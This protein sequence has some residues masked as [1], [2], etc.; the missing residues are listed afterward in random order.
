MHQTRLRTAFLLIRILPV[1]FWMFGWCVIFR[2]THQ[3]QPG[4]LSNRKIVR[5]LV[6]HQDR[7]RETRDCRL[8]RPRQPF[9]FPSSAS[10]AR[11]PS[12]EIAKRSA[13]A[14]A[15]AVIS[16]RQYKPARKTVRGNFSEFPV[17]HHHLAP[18]PTVLITDPR[19]SLRHARQRAEPRTAIRGPRIYV[20][21]RHDDGSALRPFGITPTAPRPPASP[22]QVANPRIPPIGQASAF[23]PGGITPPPRPPARV[24]SQ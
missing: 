15:V 10:V 5:G 4:R 8:Q 22:P 16:G 1:S 12:K 6:Q 24:P 13:G 3:R 14:G 11:I 2:F 19:R 18:I 21:P 17:N 20:A 9:L 7:A 23:R